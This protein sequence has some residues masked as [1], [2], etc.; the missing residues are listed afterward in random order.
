MSSAAK[1]T[2][3]ETNATSAMDTIALIVLAG[4]PTAPSQQLD[5][6]SEK[7]DLETQRCQRTARRARKLDTLLS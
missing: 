6:F 3:M 7:L 4:R 2:E 5:K 1:A